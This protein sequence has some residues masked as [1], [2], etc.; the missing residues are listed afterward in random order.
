VA[1]VETVAPP[2]VPVRAKGGSVIHLMP[3]ALVGPEYRTPQMSLCGHQPGDERN[4]ARP[5]A[6]WWKV[7]DGWERLY[8]PCKEC[9][10]I[11]AGRTIGSWPKP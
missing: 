2:T 6:G 10:R 9:I 1:E 8:R 3:M 4:S 11:N 5:R 7:Q